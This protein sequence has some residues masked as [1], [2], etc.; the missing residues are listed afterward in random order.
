[1][2]DLKVDLMVDLMVDLKISLKISLM[3]WIIIL[4]FYPINSSNCSSNFATPPNFFEI[5]LFGLRKLSNQRLHRYFCGEVI[6]SFSKKIKLI[7]I[8][9]SMLNIFGQFLIVIEINIEILLLFT[10]LRN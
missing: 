1:M 4:S 6:E 9:I 8:F 2:V 10:Y 5:L 3:G 7:Y